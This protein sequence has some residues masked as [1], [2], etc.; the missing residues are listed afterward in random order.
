MKMF[1]CS[2]SALSIQNGE[3][4]IG[5]GSLNFGWNS[6]ALDYPVSLFL[7]NNDSLYVSDTLNN[8]VLKY[9]LISQ[10]LTTVAGTGVRGSTMNQLYYP[11]GLHVDNAYN[12]YVVDTGN[13]RIMLWNA[14]ASFGVLVAGTGVVGNTTD[15]FDFPRSIVVDSTGNMF[16]CDV[17]N[18]RIMKWAPNST[19][20]VIFTG[21]GLPGNGIGEL[22]V[23]RDIALD[24]ENRWLYILDSGNNRIQRCSLD[25]GMN[26][27]TAIGRAVGS[28]MNQTLGGGSHLYLSKRTSNI[29]ASSVSLHVIVR[30]R[31]NSNG[32]HIIAGIQNVAGNS[33]TLLDGPRGIAVDADE[34]FIYVVD[35]ENDR[36]QRFRLI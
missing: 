5:N 11:C 16:I 36:I 24:E 29:Y 4:I 9:N 14:N 34:K 22:N 25:D 23:P 6:T 19:S 18:N 15:T 27:T 32:S 31:M 28:V 17:G 35:S 10:S 3:T 1:I 20:G 26:C 12:I 8:R 7:H 30:W 33:A 21:T 2:I 13:N